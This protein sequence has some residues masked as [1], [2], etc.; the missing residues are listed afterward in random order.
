MYVHTQ[1]PPQQS[2]NNNS[3]VKKTVEVRVVELDRTARKDPRHPLYRTLHFSSSLWKQLDADRLCYVDLA[4][5]D[6]LY[7]ILIRYVVEHQQ[8]NCLTSFWATATDKMNKQGRVIFDPCNEIRKKGSSTKDD[9][10]HLTLG[11]GLHQ[12]EFDGCQI[13]ILHQVI[14]D[15][16][17]TPAGVQRLRRTILF[18]DAAE[19][20]RSSDSDSSGST[21]I[22]SFCDALIEWDERTI[23]RVYRIYQWNARRKNWQNIATKVVRPV[24]SV[25]L[26]R[27]L[28]DSI[29]DDIDRFASDASAQW[30]HHHGIPYKRSYLFHGPPGVGKSSFIRVLA[31]HLRR[32][33]CILPLAGPKMTDESLQICLQKAPENSLLVLEDIDALFA[34]DRSSQSDKCPLTF[35]GLLNAL[36][37]IA[38]RDGQIFMITTNHIDRLD[39]A[40]IR[41]GRV[42]VRVSFPAHVTS[43]QV[44]GIFLHFYPGEMESANRFTAEIARRFGV[45]EEEESEIPSKGKGKTEGD[46][47]EEEGKLSMAAL[48]QHFIDCRTLSAAQAVERLADFVCA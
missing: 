45:K 17:G 36:D 10:N 11:L 12:I 24:E 1:L 44:R 26:P 8:A 31:G 48:Q 9:D 41:P 47:E 6:P 28:K 37:G 15:P 35:S 5:T 30:Y 39:S 22:R 33:L 7:S 27:S 21:L 14:G 34:K 2:H 16:Q 18:A 42:D 32:H 23:E 20:N 3:E 13:R 4:S 29:L 46:K 25:V 43:E 40:L 19:N 38:N